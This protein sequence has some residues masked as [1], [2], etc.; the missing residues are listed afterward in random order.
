MKDQFN[1][2]TERRRPP[3]YLTGHEIYEMGKDV[4]IVLGK[5]KRNGKKTKEDDM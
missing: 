2:N 4:H 5:R 3:P 1:G